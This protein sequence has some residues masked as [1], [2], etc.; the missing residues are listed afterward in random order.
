VLDILILEGNVIEAGGW[1]KFV[2]EDKKWR[3]GDFLEILAVQLE[4][5]FPALEGVFGAEIYD[6]LVEVFPEL[7]RAANE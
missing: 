3:A 6:Y 5:V 4:R 2:Y 7:K 1:Y